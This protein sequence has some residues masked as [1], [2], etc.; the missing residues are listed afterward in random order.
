MKK[1]GKDKTIWVK[2]FF[3]DKEL[4][5]YEKIKLID[6]NNFLKTIEESGPN[7]F[8]RMEKAPIHIVAYK[9]LLE[10]LSNKYVDKIIFIIIGYF[11][12]LL[13]DKIF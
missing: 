7:P 5:R 9:S 2:Q 1:L 8:L 12:K 11:L 13:L 6:Y 3:S 4:W 10:F